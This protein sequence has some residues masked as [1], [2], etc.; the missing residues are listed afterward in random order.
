MA[1]VENGGLLG[2]GQI[3]LGDPELTIESLS[4]VFAGPDHLS[5]TRR[6]TGELAR[7]VSCARKAQAVRL[8]GLLIDLAS[9]CNLN[10]L[11]G[12]SLL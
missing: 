3:D 6:V 2:T 9:E 8:A 4:I 11:R 5:K 1:L 10:D 7:A 12:G